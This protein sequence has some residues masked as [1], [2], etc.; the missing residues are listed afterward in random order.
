M[1]CIEKMFL[2]GVSCIRDS[3]LGIFFGL[4][5]E[6]HQFYSGWYEADYQM[7]PVH[8]CLQDTMLPTPV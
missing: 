3:R 2:T 7:S 6:F 5:V 1:Y 4:N 8:D